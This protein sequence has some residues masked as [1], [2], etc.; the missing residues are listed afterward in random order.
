MLSWMVCPERA[1]VGEEDWPRKL[2]KK[3]SQDSSTEA[4]SDSQARWSSSR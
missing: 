1:A 2:R 3:L 4:G